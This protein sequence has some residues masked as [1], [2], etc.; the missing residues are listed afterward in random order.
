MLSKFKVGI[1]G[2]GL[3]ASNHVYGYLNS[4]KFEIV[5]LADPYVE[6]MKDFDDDAFLGMQIGN[7]NGGGILIFSL[8]LLLIICIISFFYFMIKKTN[9]PIYLKQK[10][11][12]KGLNNDALPN[13]E[14]SNDTNPTSNNK[15][16]TA[17]NSNKD[18]PELQSLQ[19]T[20]ASLTVGEK[21]SA[22]NLINEWLEDNP[23]NNESSEE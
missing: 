16:E 5:A 18:T 23:N 14:K 20:A 3:M 10:I 15:P 8:F 2:C 1:I 22:S 19:Q 17:I 6:A 13:N 4:E 9:T 12:P 7:S 11:K 21:E